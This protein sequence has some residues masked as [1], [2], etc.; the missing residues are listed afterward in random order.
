MTFIIAK[1]AMAA[2]SS[3]PRPSPSAG[4]QQALGRSGCRLY[5]SGAIQRGDRL[6]P[7]VRIRWAWIETR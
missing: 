7:A 1:P 6:F 2:G 4:F 5:C 3:S